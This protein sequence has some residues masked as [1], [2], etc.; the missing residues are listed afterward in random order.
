MPSPLGIRITPNIL[1]ICPDFSYSY[2]EGF[3]YCRNPPMELI[4]S[5]R[6]K[7]NVTQ[8]NPVH[9]DQHVLSK[10]FEALLEDSMTH[11]LPT[12]LGGVAPD[13]LPLA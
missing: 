3:L 8:S 2:V 5:F 10:S 1:V 7:V 6:F 4:F 13:A 11:N 12:T 9:T